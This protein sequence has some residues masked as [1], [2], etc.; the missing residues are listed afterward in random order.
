MK[1]P[2]CKKTLET[3]EIEGLFTQYYVI[4]A[5]GN[6]PSV[7]WSEAYD[8]KE[9]AEQEIQNRID[10]KEFMTLIERVL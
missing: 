4:C 10:N 3:I 7:I 8:T 9:Q 2:S 6:C 1:C 5:N